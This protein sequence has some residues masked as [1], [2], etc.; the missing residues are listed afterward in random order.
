MDYKESESSNYLLLQES[1]QYQLCNPERDRFSNPECDS[2]PYEAI[3]DQFMQ[4]GSIF[5]HDQ[6]N[7]TNIRYA[8]K[9]FYNLTHHSKFQISLPVFKDF[10][11]ANSFFIA[12]QTQ[13]NNDKNYGEY[14]FEIISNIWSF[15]TDLSS[16]F[17]NESFAVILIR[18]CNPQHMPDLF[19]FAMHAIANYCAISKD[20]RDILLSKNIFPILLTYIKRE[21]RIKNVISGLRLSVNLI[22]PGTDQIYDSVKQLIPILRVHLQHINTEIRKLASKCLI[23]ILREDHIS[24]CIYNNIHIKLFESIIHFNFQPVELIQLANIFIDNGCDSEYITEDFINFL[25]HTLEQMPEDHDSIQE[26]CTLLTTIMPKVMPLLLQTGIVSSLI[27]IALNGSFKNTKHATLLLIRLLPLLDAETQEQIS[28]EGA[29]EACLNL[30]GSGVVSSG[31]YSVLI[32]STILNIIKLNEP[33]FIGLAVDQDFDSVLD[34]LEVEDEKC[35][36]I[37]ELLKQKVNSQYE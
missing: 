8:I 15:C 11:F 9:I 16:P 23:L 24:D 34:S 1:R 17:T 19:P 27:K 25:A 13:A 37:I 4:S 22:L 21:Q 32:Y 33:R 12:L 30:A 26:I 36:E 3:L 6:N 5:I 14:C 29:F 31:K 7:L 10:E 2:E 28:Y 18:N 35:Q 20:A